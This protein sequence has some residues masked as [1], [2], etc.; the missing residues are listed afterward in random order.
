[1]STLRYADR[2]KNIINAP[3]VNEVMTP[4]FMKKDAPA[5]PGQKQGI[6]ISVY[7][8]VLCESMK[9]ELR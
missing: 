2:A 8:S 6:K 1:M 9:L 5:Y 4:W 7:F 3:T